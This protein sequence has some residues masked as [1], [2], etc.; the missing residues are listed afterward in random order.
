M[1]HQ[2]LS[3][4]E[5]QLRARTVPQPANE[6]RARVLGR[7]DA[8]QRHERSVRLVA[9]ATAVLSIAAAI[10]LVSSSQLPVAN[11]PRTTNAVVQALLA[12]ELG[13][14]A[15][16]QRRVQLLLAHARLPRIAPPRGSMTLDL[17][18]GL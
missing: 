16:E 4:L 2:D 8:I 1:N 11:T 9:T 17:E 13:L 6:L 18:R 10:A 3:S 7:L 5:G 14:D 15:H 12:E